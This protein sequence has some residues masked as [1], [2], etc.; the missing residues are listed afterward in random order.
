MLRR[1]ISYI[2]QHSAR[3]LNLS[4]FE[5]EAGRFGD[6]EERREEEENRGDELHGERDPPLRGVSVGDVQLD[7]VVAPVG[8]EGGE[9]TIDFV[10]SNLWED[11]G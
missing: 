3:F 6:E 8:G 1:Q 4:I 2:S 11:G 10:E 9:L 7:D 5:E